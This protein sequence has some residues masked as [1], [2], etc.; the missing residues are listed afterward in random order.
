[1][2]IQIKSYFERLLFEGDFSNIKEAVLAALKNKANLC[3]AELCDAELCG[4]NLCGANL[5]D[6]DLCDADLCGIKIKSIRVFSGLY[7]YTIFAILDYKNVRYVKMGCLF[8][9]LEEWDKIGILNSNIKEF[10]N[11]GSR[12]SKERAEAF[13]FAKNAALNLE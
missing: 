9:S 2:K 4:A 11:D 10:P 8:Y 12:K 1:M 7:R 6:A 3:D 5:C 13:E